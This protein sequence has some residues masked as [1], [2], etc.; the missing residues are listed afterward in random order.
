MATASHHRAG[1]LTTLA[2]LFL[3]LSQNIAAL[4]L[5]PLILIS[6]VLTLTWIGLPFVILTGILLRTLADSQRRTLSHM[7]IK[8]SKPPRGRTGTPGLPNPTTR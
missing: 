2:Y 1:R 6:A 5:L 7:L 4:L 8:N 3:L